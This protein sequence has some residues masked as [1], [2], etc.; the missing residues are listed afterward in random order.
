MLIGRDR[1]RTDQFGQNLGEADRGVGLPIRGGGQ[2][3][4]IPRQELRSRPCHVLAP[5]GR[6]SR[7]R[8]KNVGFW[9]ALD[10]VRW[11]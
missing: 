2:L 11:A 7:A 6:R 3:R 8:R 4:R 1:L 9:G 10:S 5:P